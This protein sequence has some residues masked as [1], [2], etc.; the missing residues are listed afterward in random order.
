MS[1]DKHDVTVIKLGEKP[2]EVTYNCDIDDELDAG[3][4]S[5]IIE[6]YAETFDPLFFTIPEG[7]DN[8]ENE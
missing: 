1:E 3:F 4:G 5:E 6:I 2:G 8:I 7:Y